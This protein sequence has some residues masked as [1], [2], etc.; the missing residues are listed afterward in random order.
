MHSPE[1]SEAKL[2]AKAWAAG[3]YD[4]GRTLYRKAIE[5]AKTNTGRLP[6]SFYLSEWA[7]MEGTIRNREAFESLS[8]EAL[9]LEP[10]APL[11]RLAYARE[12]W[13]EFQDQSAC[14]RAISDLEEL[15]A[16]DRWDRSIDLAP[17]AYSQKIETLRARA[18]GEQGGTLWP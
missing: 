11:L 18:N 9:A 10:N 2:A 1:P 7:R 4:V 12:L 5:L 3:E 13:A 17:L 15:L 14:L 16:S 6:P 8:R